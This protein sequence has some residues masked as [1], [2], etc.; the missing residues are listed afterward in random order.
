MHVDIS[1]KNIPNADRKAVADC[2]SYLGK[3]AAFKELARMFK[4]AQEPKDFHRLNFLC[5]MRIGIQ[6]F[7]FFALIRRYAGQEKF[8]AYWDS[9][10]LD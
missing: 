9:G 2:L 6:G 4:D 8:K 7:P 5:A 10:L 3:P 1:Y